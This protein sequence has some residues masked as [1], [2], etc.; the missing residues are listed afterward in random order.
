[1][2]HLLGPGLA[3]DWRIFDVG[4]HRSLVR[5]SILLPELGLTLLPERYEDHWY[6]RNQLTWSCEQPHGLHILMTWMQSSSWL[7][8]GK[9]DDLHIRAPRWFLQSC[10]DQ[11]LVEDKK[12]NRLVRILYITRIWCEWNTT[13]ILFLNK[14]DI[15]KAKLVSGIKLADYVVSYGD[16]PN[17][18]EHVSA[19]EERH[20][21]HCSH[22]TD[23][24]KNR[25]PKEVWFVSRNPQ[26]SIPSGIDLHTGAILKEK[27]VLSRPLYCHLTAVTVGAMFR[28]IARKILRFWSRI[29]SRRRTSF[30][31]VR[32]CGYRFNT[33]WS[34][35]S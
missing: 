33:N 21:F 3:R 15:L 35:C 20:S 9:Y 19:C 2:A 7:P 10:F 29:R 4:G 30:G 1:M 22:V 16:R 17:D 23:Q 32:C 11:V 31:M 27:S 14:I 34:L 13:L 18:F 12:V 28:P 8:L 5:V 24:M 25:F 6:T 26:L